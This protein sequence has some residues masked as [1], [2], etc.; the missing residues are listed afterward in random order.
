MKFKK[1]KMK[2]SPIQTKK[3]FTLI[4]LLVVI[5]IIAILAAM[6]LP[7]LSKAKARA[8]QAQCASNLKQWGIAITMYAGDNGDHFP[9]NTKVALNEPSWVDLSFNTN[10]FPVYLYNNRPGSTTTGLRSQNDVLYCPTDRWHRSYEA[11]V[12]TTSL[13]L[14][15]NWL[16]ARATASMYQA[17]GLQNWF[18]RTKLGSSYRNAPVMVDVVQTYSGSWIATY[19]GPFSYRGPNSNHAD[20]NG[21]PSGANFL[22]EDGHVVWMKFDGTTNS[23]APMDNSSGSSTLNTGNVDYGRPGQLGTGPW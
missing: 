7:A 17:F 14:G 1:M 18:Y 4:E 23:I 10:F 5:A 15:Y 21:K 11:S 2:L 8:Y 3:A 22:Y 16:P 12:A 19:T 20:N 9:D 6:L 13:L